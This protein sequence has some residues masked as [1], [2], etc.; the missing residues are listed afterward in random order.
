MLVFVEFDQHYRKHC[1][2]K[3][4]TRLERHSKG[5]SFFFSSITGNYRDG[6]ELSYCGSRTNTW[7]NIGWKWVKIP[8]G[9]NEDVV[10]IL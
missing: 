2:T 7:E 6:G 3:Y 1:Y 4:V 5:E 9:F 10:K 8:V